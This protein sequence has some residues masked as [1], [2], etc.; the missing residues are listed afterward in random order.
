MKFETDGELRRAIGK[1]LPMS[2]VDGESIGFLRFDALGAERF[3]AA[4]EGMMRSGEGLKLWYLSTITRLVSEGCEVRTV[5]IEGLDWGE[6]DFLPDVDR[7]PEMTSSWAARCLQPASMRERR[8]GK[9][10]VGTGR[11][12]GTR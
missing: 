3:I 7:N 9:E 11:A 10:V 8:V 1:T 4:L 5:S 6:M 2:T 12:R